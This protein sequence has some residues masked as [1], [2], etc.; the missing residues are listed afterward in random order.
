MGKLI[1]PSE[2]VVKLVNEEYEKTGLNTYGIDI[3]VFSTTKAAYPMKVSKSNKTTEYL[4]KKTDFICVEVYEAA[5]E[6]MNED[7]QRK[8]IEMYLS[9][10]SYDSEKDKLAIQNNPYKI[11][12]NM[13][14]K[15]GCGFIDKLEAV[16]L[17]IEQIDEQE[18]EQREATKKMKIK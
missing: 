7:D 11:L 12:F 14:K 9:G 13:T 16:F 1:D 2:D 17:A 15:Y 10:V 8:I 18:K 5:L 4:V 6:Q 3:E